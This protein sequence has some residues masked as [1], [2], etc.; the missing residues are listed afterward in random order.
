MRKIL[1]LSSLILFVSCVTNAQEYPNLK[2][3]HAFSGTLMIGA[4]AGVTLGYTDYSNTKPQIVGRGV[5]EYFFPTTSNGIFGLKGFM[6]AG[7]VGGKDSRK[8]PTEFRASVTRIGG[9]ITYTFSIK[10]TV[11]PYVFLGASYGWIN[12]RDIN[13]YDLPYAGRSFKITEVNYHGEVGVRLLLSDA[14]NFN[15]NVGTEFSPND[16]WDGLTPSGSN[17]LLFQA[18]AG[19]SYS[20]FTQT[21]ED[22]DGVPD[23]KDQCPNT[24]PGVKVDDFG[25]PIDSDNDGVPDYK[26]K[27]PNTEAGMQVDESGCAIDADHD[28]VPDKYDKCPNTSPGAKVNEHGCPDTDND[29][30]YDDMDNC[31]NTPEGAPVDVKGCPKD[32]DGDGVPDYKDECP[33]TPKGREVDEKGCEIKKDTVKVSL[34]GDTNFESGKATLLSNAYSIL[35]TLVESMKTDTKAKLRIEG[36]TDSIGSESFN[37]ELSRK[38]AQAVADY[39]ISQGIDSSRLEVIPMGESNPIASNKTAEGRAMNRRVEIIPEH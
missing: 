4:E 19:F 10:Q 30:V 29:G 2:K 38:R 3:H 27:C 11:F 18:M 36:Y 22:G 17:D 20:L 28:G 21:D 9:G 8:N 37:L 13:S 39:L 24:P 7:Y 25:C 5:L 1:I 23:S 32:S 14:I 16:N 31:P 15:I 6:S 12:P 35:N 26:D 34:S 33:N